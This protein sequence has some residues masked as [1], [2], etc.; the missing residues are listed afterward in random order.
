M[1][2]TVGE[3]WWQ[4][5]DI[6]R[7]CNPSFPGQRLGRLP[8]GRASLRGWKGFRGESGAQEV[9]W[10]DVTLLVG[11]GQVFGFARAERP[12]TIAEGV[13]Y[14]KSSH[15]MI[16]SGRQSDKDNIRNA[17]RGSFIISA[18]PEEQF[19]FTNDTRGIQINLTLQVSFVADFDWQMNSSSE[20]RN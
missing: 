18:S 6:G 19:D 13:R 1:K 12:R 10:R 9:T 11:R 3:N 4:H 14:R 17:R 5:E 16:T 2:K 8:W 20:I 7:V 15:I